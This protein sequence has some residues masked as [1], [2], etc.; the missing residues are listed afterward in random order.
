[1]GIENILI[2]LTPV[3]QRLV[4]QAGSLSPLAV[5]NIAPRLRM[6]TLYALAQDRGYLVLGTGNASELAMGYF[7]KY[8]DGGCDANPIS[9]LSAPSVIEVLKNVGCPGS[10]TSKAPSAGLF[11]GQTDEADMGVT[12][13][14]IEAFLGYLETGKPPA[15]S[16]QAFEKMSKMHT[17]TAHKRAMPKKFKE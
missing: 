16:K 1:L 12:Y 2:D 8:G 10:I 5:S 11:E 14:E 15:V 17:S 4:E 9:D 3:R 13:Q 6:T 7:T